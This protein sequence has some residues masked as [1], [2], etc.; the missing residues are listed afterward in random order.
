MDWSGAYVGGFL[1]YG[2]GSYEQ[3]VSAEDEAGPTVD[4]EG[5]M[6]GLRYGMNWQTDNKVYGFDL[7]IS[8][9]IDGATPQG[10]NGPVYQCGT[11]DCY[12]TIKNLLTARGRYGIGFNDSRTLAYGAGG[13]AIGRVEGGI[14]NSNYEAGP[15]TAS[16]YTVG[17]GLEHKI[18]SRISAYGEINYVDLGTLEFGENGS[19]DQYDGTG[20]FTTVLVGVNYQF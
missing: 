4:V 1:G 18:N 11:G 9:G 16:G 12:V 7:S 8:S 2:S 19:G 14:A 13:V 15:N 17:I 6:G 3:G 10:T 5:A 20:D